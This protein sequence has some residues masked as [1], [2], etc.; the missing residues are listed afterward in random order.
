M[1]H[2]IMQ[3]YRCWSQFP[4]VSVLLCNNI[5]NLNESQL[6]KSEPAHQFDCPLIQR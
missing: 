6:L 5:H 1:K 4:R 2:L 3:M